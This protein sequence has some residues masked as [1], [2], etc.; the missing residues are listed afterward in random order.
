MAPVR[1][2]LAQMEMDPSRMD[3]SNFGVAT[4]ALAGASIAPDNRPI[5]ARLQSAVDRMLPAIE[6]TVARLGA[7]GT[8]PRELERAARAL[9]MLTRTWRE[10]NDLL[11]QRQAAGPEEDLDTL[12][13]Q[14][15]DKLEALVA[16]RADREAEAGAP[17]SNPE[18]Y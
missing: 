12:R 3:A 8:P 10:L 2:A 13:A 14:I 11:S 5:T 17:P 1:A 6:V 16:S 15:A 4:P 7:P 9:A 18:L